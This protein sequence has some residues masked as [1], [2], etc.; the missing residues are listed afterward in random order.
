MST[1]SA[2]SPLCNV[3]QK[4]GP[5]SGYRQNS[6][7]PFTIDAV[8]AI[9]HAI[10]NLQHDLCSGDE[11]CGE[12]VEYS[13]GH[14]NINGELLKTYL[15]NVNFSGESTDVIHFNRNG[16]QEGSYFIKALKVNNQGKVPV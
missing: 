5:G 13:N 15:Q 2:W 14:T 3:S 9:A 7:V 8:Y 12:I 6:K 1:Q 10:N 11:I 16:D 4:I